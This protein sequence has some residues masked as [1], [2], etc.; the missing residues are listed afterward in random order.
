MGVRRLQY[1]LCRGML[2]LLFV[3]LNSVIYPGG[4]T[5]QLELALTQLDGFLLTKA[6][7]WLCKQLLVTSSC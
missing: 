6:R 4:L 1:T 7:S 5:G 2:A 3:I